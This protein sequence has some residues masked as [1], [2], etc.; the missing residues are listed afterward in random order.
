MQQGAGRWHLPQDFFHPQQSLY[1]HLLQQEQ[2]QENL[3]QEQVNL[4]KEQHQQQQ[5]VQQQ[6]Q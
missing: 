6:Q 2:Q 3:Q 1:P 5:W 4:Q